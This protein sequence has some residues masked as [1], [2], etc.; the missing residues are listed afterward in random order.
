MLEELNVTNVVH[1]HLLVLTIVVAE[2][3]AVITE[4]EVVGDMEIVEGEEATTM[5][6][7]MLEVVEQ[8]LMVVVREE[9]VVVMLKV[10]HMLL[11]LMGQLIAT[12][13]HHLIPMVGTLMPSPRPRVML[14]DLH[15]IPLHMVPL[16]AMVGIK[17]LMPVGVE[18]VAHRED[19]MGDMAVV[20]GMQVVMIV[21]QLR[22]RKRSSNVMRTV[23]IS[24][25]T[26]EYI[27]QICLLM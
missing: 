10:L 25:T 9:M 27:S 7:E 18:G 15:L 8:V 26:Q 4:V 13:H 17:Q 24:V 14:V 6:T 1:L 2:V 20:K 23:E 11:H 21:P 16:V 22:L 19:M 3:V 12:I 5:M